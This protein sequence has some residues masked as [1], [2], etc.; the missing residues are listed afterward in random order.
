MFDCARNK[1]VGHFKFLSYTTPWGLR[2]RSIGQ[3]RLARDDRESHQQDW[4]CTRCNL[5][6]ISGSRVPELATIDRPG[7]QR[8]LLVAQ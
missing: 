7:R 4:R 8:V 3:G 1:L 2:V 5:I 6:I